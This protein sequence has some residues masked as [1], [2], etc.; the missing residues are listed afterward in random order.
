MEASETLG[1]LE[2]FPL[3]FTGEVLC[4]EAPRSLEGCWRFAFGLWFGEA[5]DKLAVGPAWRGVA[6]SPSDV[7]QLCSVRPS[8]S[9]VVLPLALPADNRRNPGSPFAEPLE[10][11][12]GTATAAGGGGVGGG[13]GGGGSVIALPVDV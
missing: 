5:L 11:T 4:W 10:L 8:K 9:G 3:G 6:L 7:E 13:G 2:G 1:A 12:R